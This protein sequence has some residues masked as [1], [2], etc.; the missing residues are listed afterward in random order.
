MQEFPCHQRPVPLRRFKARFRCALSHRNHTIVALASIPH[1]R[2]VLLL[3]QRLELPQGVSS[4]ARK[5]APGSLPPRAPAAANVRT[6]PPLATLW[7]EHQ[8]ARGAADTP[9]PGRDRGNDF[10]VSGADASELDDPYFVY[11]F[12]ADGGSS[13]FEGSSYAADDVADVLEFMPPEMVEGLAQRGAVMQ[14]QM[15]AQK[16]YT[17]EAQKEKLQHETRFFWQQ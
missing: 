2:F 15:A 1:A 17:E 14:A 5:R 10:S 11:D 4:E 9:A 3:L 16:K 13:A 8:D 7:P 6:A 12:D